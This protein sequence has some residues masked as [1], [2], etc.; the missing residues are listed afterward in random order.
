MTPP[1]FLGGLADELAE[2]LA[3]IEDALRVE[4]APHGVDEWDERALQHALAAALRR[5]YAVALE[6][7]YPSTIGGKRS[8]ERRCDLVVSAPDR[9]LPEDALWLELKVARQRHPSGA[10]DARY[11]QQ[12]R[13]HLIADLRKLAAEPRIRAAAIVLVAFTE[14]EATLARDLD[15]FE[16][17]MVR[18]DVVAGFRQVRA[19]PVIDRIGHRVGAVAMWPL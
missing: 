12:W 13:R 7:P 3:A 8:K 18:A 14:D 5:R 16:S 2:G 10:R 6:A 1:W 19:V 15:Q 9:P 4:A 11:A 17:V